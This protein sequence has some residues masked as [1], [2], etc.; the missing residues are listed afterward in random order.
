M[1]YASYAV[2][3]FKNASCT[4]DVKIILHFLFLNSLSREKTRS[5]YSINC[6]NSLWL[7]IN[8]CHMELLDKGDK[9]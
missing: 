5:S 4:F 2:N 7:F 8:F 6:S 1:N 9:Y 3:Y